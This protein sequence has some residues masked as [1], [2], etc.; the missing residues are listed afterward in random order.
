MPEQLLTN[1]K[2][3]FQSMKQLSGWKNMLKYEKSKVMWRA[4]RLF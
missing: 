4:V 2:L 3:L 1:F